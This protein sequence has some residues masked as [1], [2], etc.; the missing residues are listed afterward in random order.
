MSRLRWRWEERDFGFRFRARSGR[1]AAE[2]Y[3]ARSPGDFYI[4]PASQRKFPKAQAD[5]LA[6]S[7]QAPTAP[8]VVP[9]PWADYD[10]NWDWIEGPD[11]ILINY[12]GCL[13]QDEILRREDQGVARV[14]ELVIDL[15]GRPEPAAL[16]VPLV[17]QMHRA[18]LG[19]IYPFAGAWR[20][21]ALH[22]GAHFGEVE[23][24]FRGC[25]TPI[26]AKWNARRSAATLSGRSLPFGSRRAPEILPVPPVT[27]RVR[28][29]QGSRC[30][31]ARATPGRRPGEAF[32]QRVLPRLAPVPATPGASAPGTA[33]LVGGGR[34]VL[35]FAETTRSSSSQQPN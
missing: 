11:G 6:A 34:R 20:T 30:R 1:R 33:G 24:A 28:R 10:H 35:R 13:D 8:R 7:A 2:H 14:H 23:H 27:S 19:Q 12:A 29:V 18:L 21:V 17:Q 9:N 15:L 32:R 31:P 5:A 4:V 22:K 3:Q 16:T 26:S 25:G